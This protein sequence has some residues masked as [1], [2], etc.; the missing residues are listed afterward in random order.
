MASAYDAVTF[1]TQ[2]VAHQG[3]HLE[4][5]LLAQLKQFRDGPI[6]VMMTEIVLRE[7]YRHLTERTKD[8]RDRFASEHRKAVEHGLPVAGTDP[9]DGKDVDINAVVRE[10]LTKFVQEIGAGLVRA[11][12]VPMKTLT[13]L[14][15]T[16][17]APFAGSGKKKNEFPDAIALLALEHWSEEQD[18]RVLA[19]SGDKD[20]AAFAEKSDRIDVVDSLEEALALLQEN[21]KAAEDY[22]QTLI[23][24]LAGEGGDRLY[25]PLCRMLRDAVSGWQVHAEANSYFTVEGGDAELKLLDFA[26]AEA[27]IRIVQVG[28][29]G[30]SAVVEVDATVEAV[31]SFSL[32]VHDSID[33]D[34]VP[35]GSAYAQVQ[36]EERFGVLLHFA[37]LWQE[38][39]EDVELDSVEL[40]RGPAMIDFE[41]VEPDYSEDYEPDEEELIRLAV[42]NEDDIP[43]TS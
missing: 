12:E 13:D 40:V 23:P 41:W 37:G 32:S 4:G 33:G 27:P 35:M 8:V 21:V 30:I 9:F 20:W 22:V 7:L 34:D 43:T 2:V 36:V 28:A 5:G 6:H 39:E 17:G 14:Y 38:K 16:T 3:Y 31:G 29:K 1:D 42:E 18:Y 25:N 15:F 11:D 24:E 19:V 10:R 26:V